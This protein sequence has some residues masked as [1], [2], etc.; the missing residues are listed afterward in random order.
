MPCGFSSLHLESEQKFRSMPIT[1]RSRLVSPFSWLRFPAFNHQSEGAILT[2]IVGCSFRIVSRLLPRFISYCATKRASG[3]SE[4]ARYT[5]HRA[6]LSCSRHRPLFAAGSL[7]PM[8]NDVK[9]GRPHFDRMHLM[10]GE[11]RCC[12]DV[13]VCSTSCSPRGAISWT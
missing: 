1:Y 8:H 2:E 13:R 11:S 7:R 12:S 10:D 6:P 3:R 9:T 4:S 5:D